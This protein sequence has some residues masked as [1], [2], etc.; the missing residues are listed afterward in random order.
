MLL[1]VIKRRDLPFTWG[2]GR[3]RTEYT[4]PSDISKG[5]WIAE[6]GAIAPNL[7]G[8]Q[9]TES[10]NHSGW[11]YR[12]KESPDS[13]GGNLWIDQGTDVG[14][15]FTMKRRCVEQ[16]EMVAPTHRVY[17][18]F[19]PSP[20]NGRLWRDIYDGPIAF[21]GI[22]GF[23]PYVQSSDIELNFWGTKAIAQ[24]AP[25]NNIA[26]LA[27]AL[28]ELRKDGIPKVLG[29]TLWKS[30]IRNARETAKS[31]GGEY[32]NLEFG[33]KP[34]VSDVTDVAKGIAEF[35]SVIEQYIRDSGRVV[36]RRYNFPSITSE[37]TTL[38]SSN[39]T[40]LTSPSSKFLDPQSGR[41]SVF[42]LRQ[43]TIDRW[44][45]GAFTYHIPDD[46]ESRRGVLGL[47]EKARQVLGLE[48]N[49]DVLWNVAPWSWATDWFANTGDIISNLTDWSSDG[50]VMRYGY[51][52]EHTV[53]RDH[54]IYSG[55]TGFY[56]GNSAR[57][58]LLT[59]VAETKV[60]RR[61]SPFGFGINLSS[62]TGRQNAILAALGLSRLR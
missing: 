58:P 54:Y 12:F 10:E 19:V 50:L 20:L 42:R 56:P 62:L 32:L 7:T 16:P 9:E 40:A 24:C 53:N 33:W 8:I 46:F 36:R 30:R 29:S 13:I 44:F 55:P 51:I 60:R 23:P 4:N 22:A 3:L 39:A 38:L 5:T 59:L 1:G 37:N 14:G 11:Q 17:S 48:L 49:P 21:P 52:M 35:D 28:I 34:L 47:A 2:R 6:D 15:N 31:S 45:S 43:T 25:T 61:A 18:P 41:G 57:P 27:T 26:G